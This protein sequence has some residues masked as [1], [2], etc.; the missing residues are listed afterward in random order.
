M[1][2]VYWGD[3][4]MDTADDTVEDRLGSNAPIPSINSVIVAYGT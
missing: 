4:G 1:L 2:L 3:V